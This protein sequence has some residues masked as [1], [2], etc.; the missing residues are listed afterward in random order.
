MNINRKA[1]IEKFIK[2]KTKTSEIVDF[3]MNA[4]Q[5]KLYNII[6]EQAE[7]NK[8]IRLIILKSRQMGISTEIESL[9][10]S[11]T[12]LKFNVSTGIVTHDSAAT[13]NLFEMSKLMYQC[14][15]D[16]LKPSLLKDNVN[17]L[18]FNNE[19]GTG[20]NS[21]IK[22]M[23]AGNRSIG[24]SATFQ[25]LHLSEYAFWPGDKKSTFNGLIQCVPALP[26]T[27]VVIESTPQGYDDFKDKWDKAVAGESDF[28]PVFL[29][30]YE[31]PEYSMPYDGF[32]LT[33][34]EKEMMEMYN[35]SLDQLTWRRWCIK[36]NCDND[37]DQFK[38]EYPSNPEEAFLSTG[39][40]IFDKESVVNRIQK[41]KKPLKR[42][43]FD[44]KYNGLEITGIEFVESDSKPWVEIYEDVKKGYP[45]VLG[46]DT[47]GIGKDSF[48][49]DVV[50]NNT[51]EQAATL[52]LENDEIEYTRQMYC[53]GMYYNNA[54]IGIETN[55]STYPVKE[56][57]RLGYTNQYLRTIDEGI[58][59]KIQDK[60]GFN[61]NTATRPVIIAELVKFVE[62]N[63][64]K[65]HCQNTLKQTLT[66][67]KR[68]DGKKAADNGYHDDRVMSLAITLA[69]RDQQEYLVIEPK[70]E[71]KVVLPFALQN[72][73][74]ED[75]NDEYEVFEMEW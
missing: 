73:I 66:F 61:T 13:A 74:T 63:I 7:L 55:Y 70:E 5:T 44:Y 67:I 38:Q 75:N 3:K 30:W 48:A 18:V 65:I 28:I 22:C 11:N 27:I 36:N 6:K 68:P 54:L 49:G 62:E 34:A 17:E 51:G 64:E 39:K 72:E 31:M 23:T 25:Y 35:L 14:L 32:E 15:P 37:L 60:L 4:P 50:N 24:R 9:L 45:Y 59:I 10:F 33:E 41:I 1:F 43:F 29:A 52:E 21:R 57:F 40:C 12:I 20:L 26:D 42:G 19:E 8:P 47:A 16:K 46:G 2:I 56:L 69:I 71:N 58:D 53:L